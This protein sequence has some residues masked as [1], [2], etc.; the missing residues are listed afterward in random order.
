MT[1]E[2]CTYGCRKI[3]GFLV[4]VYN[5]NDFPRVFRAAIRVRPEG[6]PAELLHPREEQLRATEEFLRGGGGW[7]VSDFL[8]A[9][10]LV[11]ERLSVRGRE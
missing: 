5:L 3:D 4:E 1:E 10:L 7:G 6:S 8:P 2:G 9:W 11:A